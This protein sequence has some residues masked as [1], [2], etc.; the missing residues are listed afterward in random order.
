M[1]RIPGKNGTATLRV[2]AWVF[3]LKEADSCCLGLRTSA[4]DS[5]QSL[6]G[7]QL[8]SQPKPGAPQRLSGLQRHFGAR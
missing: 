7:A 4:E 3:S 8:L 6:G 2:V 1:I 5:G